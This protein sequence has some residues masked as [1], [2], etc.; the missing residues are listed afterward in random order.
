MDVKEAVKIAAA[1]VANLEG[2][3]ADEQGET[4]QDKVLRDIRFAIEGTRY[5]DE[6]KLWDITVGFA[7]KWDQASATPLAGRSAALQPPRDNRT[8]KTVCID[9]V[10]GKV[11]SYGDK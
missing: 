6:H 4:D 2:M 5:D 10:S 3:A 1:Y 8:F 11:V 9:D 7:R